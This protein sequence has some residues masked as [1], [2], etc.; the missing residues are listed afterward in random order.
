M[1]N[2]IT[3][4]LTRWNGKLNRKRF[5]ITAA[6]GAA[7]LGIIVVATFN[8]TA[9]PRSTAEI[10]IQGWV[11]TLKD[12]SLTTQRQQAQQNLENAGAVAVPQLLAAL[13]SENAS[14]RQNAADMLGYIASPAATQGLVTVLRSDAV[15]TVRQKAAYSLG[16]IQD[17]AAINDLQQASITD[18][19]QI[20]RGAAADSLARIRTVLATS[21][22][23]N[24]QFVGAF[25]AAPSQSNLLFVAANRD[26]HTS[27]DGDK[28]WVTSNTVLPSQVSS[29]AV[30]PNNPQELYVG[31]E[32]MGL[33]KSTDG[34]KTWA[35]NNSG[36][37]LMPGARETISAI[38]IDPTNPNTIYLARGAWVGTGTVT[39]YPTGLMSSRDGGNTWQALSTGS[40]SEAI[41]QLAFRDGQL[42]G[43][44]GD[45]VLTL[46]TPQ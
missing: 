17:P 29:L 24:E 31:I 35:A 37:T 28:T 39:F 12:N 19:S 30:N 32:S 4:L 9:T 22:G 34:G 42:Y 46:V 8:A 21:A 41:A 3:A 23:L 20:V 36:I 45:H 15:P 5:V 11:D 7:L 14:Q 40:M 44:A 6:A 10:Q 26:L 18:R 16:E 43:L 33:Y 13:H 1:K 27:T 25:A 38:A 2:S